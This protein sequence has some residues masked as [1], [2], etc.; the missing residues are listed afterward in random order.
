M[1]NIIL[2]IVSNYYKITNFQL[3]F[4]DFNI[5]FRPKPSGLNNRE[6]IS[7]FKFSLIL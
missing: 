4:W 3:N 2:T 6:V 1:F 5:I 7:T